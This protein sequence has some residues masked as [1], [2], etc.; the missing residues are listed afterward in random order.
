MDI[1]V[2][3]QDMLDFFNQEIA[4]TIQLLINKRFP[5]P[6][7]QRR[8]DELVEMIIKRYGG[9]FNF[10][11]SP[12]SSNDN[13][14]ENRIMLVGC[15]FVD[16]KPDVVLFIPDMR[17][18]F[19]EIY[20]VQPLSGRQVYGAM[21][22]VSIMHELDHF[23][24]GLVYVSQL[25]TIE[26]ER[27]VWAAT[28][29]HTISHFVKIGWPLSSQDHQAYTAWINAGRDTNNPGWTAYITHVYGNLRSK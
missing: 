14:G 7:V 23:A 17:F 1:N 28:C 5:I 6:Q 15:R 2:P 24:L 4:P 3:T 21:V 26:V 19:Q 8:Y 20:R 25:S 29:E 10:T 9:T 12:T 27:Q 22:T 18:M 16:S 11:M 13:A